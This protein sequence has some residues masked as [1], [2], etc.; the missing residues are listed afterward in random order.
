[1]LSAYMKLNRVFDLISISLNIMVVVVSVN[2]GDSMQF[3]R[4]PGMGL[5]SQERHHLFGMI[6]LCFVSL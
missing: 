1:M 6:A 5:L 3:S 2:K 4:S